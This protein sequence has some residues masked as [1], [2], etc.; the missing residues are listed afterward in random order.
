MPRSDHSGWQRG[1]PERHVA[2]RRPPSPA[3]DARRRLAH[4]AELAAHQANSGSGPDWLTVLQRT[5]PEKAKKLQ[6][7]TPS[8][9]PLRQLHRE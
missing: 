3:E 8:A 6:Q 2:G 5:D 7:T 1:H 9:T 4:E